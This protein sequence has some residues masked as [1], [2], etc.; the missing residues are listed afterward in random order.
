MVLRVLDHVRAGTRPVRSRM[1]VDSS[2]KVRRNLRWRH[3]LPR[4]LHVRARRHLPSAWIRQR[5]KF[6][7]RRQYRDRGHWRSE[8]RRRERR[9]L[10]LCLLDCRGLP[11]ADSSLLRRWPMHI[12]DR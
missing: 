1:P 5:R 6:W 4:G 7:C 2:Y 3:L 11:T 12:G 8:W 10:W 9:R